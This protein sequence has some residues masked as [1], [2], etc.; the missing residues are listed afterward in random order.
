ML[1]YN[2]MFA[3]V[4]IGNKQYKVSP[5]DKIEVDR[6][7]GDVGENITFDRVLLTSDGKT[8]I[9]APTINGVKVT[10]KVVSHF[11]GKKLEIRRF[12]SKVRERKKIG[13]RPELTKL[14][15]VSIA[16]A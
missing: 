2:Y 4:V 13:F 9:G 6:L 15:I 14:E 12:K 11:R 16:K 10:A 1:Q 8:I 5:G 3:I 7:S